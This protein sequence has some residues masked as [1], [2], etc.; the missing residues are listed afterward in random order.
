LA[1]LPLER[2]VGGVISLARVSIFL[3]NPAHNIPPLCSSVPSL[4]WPL[5]HWA[6]EEIPEAEKIHRGALDISISVDNGLLVK[7]IPVI[8][9]L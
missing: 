2:G 5:W 1:T 8:D 6:D 9:K 7:F 3:S 4:T